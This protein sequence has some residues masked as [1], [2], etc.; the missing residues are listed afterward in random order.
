MPLYKFVLW[1]AN[2]MHVAIAIY[3]PYNTDKHTDCVLV[4]V[5]MISKLF[6]GKLQECSV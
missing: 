4:Y 5:V 1:S 3:V 2:F 6:G